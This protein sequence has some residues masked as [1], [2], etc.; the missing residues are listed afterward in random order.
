MLS[1]YVIIKLKNNAFIMTKI[2]AV[3]NKEKDWKIIHSTRS[4]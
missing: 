2:G 1:D 3:Y 4:F